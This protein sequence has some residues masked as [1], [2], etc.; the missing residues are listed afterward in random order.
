MG[1]SIEKARKIRKNIGERIYYIRTHN[2]DT[3]SD[4]ANRV[5]VSRSSISKYES[6][7]NMPNL[8]TL[9]KISKCFGYGFDIF[10]VSDD[11]FRKY[12]Y[13]GKRVY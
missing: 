10:F 8:D 9:I 5:G 13:W 3:Q 4:L 6:G 1:V 2:Y 12:L 11:E 7:Y